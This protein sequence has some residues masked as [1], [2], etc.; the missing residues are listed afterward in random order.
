MRQSP[1]LRLARPQPYTCRVSVP[2]HRPEPAIDEPYPCRCGPPRHS[3]ARLGQWPAFSSRSTLLA[4]GPGPSVPC[5]PGLSEGRR[6]L[7]TAQAP[8]LVG[9]PG[10]A[11]GSVLAVLAA[12]SP[13]TSKRRIVSSDPA[14]QRLPRSATSWH[15]P[16]WIHQ[17]SHPLALIKVL[18]AA[19]CVLVRRP[20]A[21]M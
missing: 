1:S 19:S 16:P 2:L 6:R 13:Q 8:C 4:V 7:P 20:A 14:F 9:T 17:W 18:G 3:L 15:W 10:P 5:L 12:P 11:P 21:H